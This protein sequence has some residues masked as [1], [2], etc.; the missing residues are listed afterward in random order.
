LDTVNLIITLISGAV[1]GNAAGAALSEQSLGT[2]GNSIAGILGGG[3]SAAILQTM[4]IGM[5]SGGA[6]L[7]ALAA[8]VFSGGLGGGFLMVLIALIRGTAAKI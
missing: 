7:G 6:D 2:F 5:G 1:G 4:G 3:I 8:Q